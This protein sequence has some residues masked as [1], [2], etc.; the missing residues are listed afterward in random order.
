MPKLFAIVPIDGA[1]PAIDRSVTPYNGYILADQVG[2]YGA[3]LFSGTGAQLIA[4]NALP[5]VVGI[6]AVTQ[7]GDV[8]WAELDGTITPAVRTKLNTW[9]T[10]RGYPSIPAG[11]TNRQV[12]DAVFKRINPNFDLDNFDI[13]E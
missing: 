3:Y 12:V 7:N 8:R 4:L 10:N 5:N 6:V 11:W 13:A 1:F 9:L 2:N